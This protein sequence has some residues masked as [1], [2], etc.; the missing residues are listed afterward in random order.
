MIMRIEAISEKAFAP[1]RPQ[2]IIKRRP[3]KYHQPPIARATLFH[4]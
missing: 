3:R 1:P 4:L 2:A